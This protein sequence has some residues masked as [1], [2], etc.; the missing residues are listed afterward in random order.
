MIDKENTILVSIP[1]TGTRFL[2]ERL[3]LKRTTHTTANWES[4]LGLVKGRKIIAPLRDPKSCWRSTVRRMT[5]TNTRD[6]KNVA[7]FFKA[8]Y[9][10][11]S[12]TLLYDVDFIP[13]DLRQDSRI[14]DWEPVGNDDRGE[15]E[16]APDVHLREL[17]ELPF[18]K[19]FYSLGKN[20]A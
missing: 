12:L 8:W 7:G 1:Y 9:Q 13:V 5:N 10:M 2:K 17:Y 3:G 14:Q 6:F 4:L 20:Y 18:V 19:Q 11:H 15:N 16:K